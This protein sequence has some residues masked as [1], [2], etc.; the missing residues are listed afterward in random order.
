MPANT[1]LL[2]GLSKEDGATM[3]H[4]HAV[5]R[6]RLTL[7]PPSNTDMSWSDILL[8]HL[9]YCNYYYYFTFNC[10]FKFKGMQCNVYV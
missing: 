7:H 3:S 10:H 6:L 5:N 9:M 4:M 1:N 8:V 2:D